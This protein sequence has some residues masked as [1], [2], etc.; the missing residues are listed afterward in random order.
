MH[1]AVA[2]C[3]VGED[4]QSSALLLCGETERH[5]RL[6]SRSPN[7]GASIA[8]SGEGVS[9]APRRSDSDR[10]RGRQRPTPR[11]SRTESARRCH[12]AAVIRPTFYTVLPLPSGPSMCLVGGLEPPVAGHFGD[13]G[14]VTRTATFGHGLAALRDCQG[15]GMD[16]SQQRWRRSWGT[17]N[18][19]SARDVCRR[20]PWSSS[21]SPAAIVPCLLPECDA[22]AWPPRNRWN[23]ERPSGPSR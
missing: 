20:P 22:D 23:R 3:W 8:R 5:R 10:W 2:A 19:A 4:K 16:V 18:V 21:S 12:S 11:T 9:S 7:W 17:R 13:S 15:R 1:R 6:S 14:L